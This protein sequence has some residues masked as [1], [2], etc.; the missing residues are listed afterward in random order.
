MS[1]LGDGVLKKS[2]MCSAVGLALLLGCTAPPVSPSATPTGGIGFDGS[3]NLQMASL[4]DDGTGRVAL[5]G[6]M[7]AYRSGVSSFTLSSPAGLTCTGQTDET[8][9]GQQTCSDGS[10]FTFT[11]PA[12][13]RG[14]LSG[15]YIVQAPGVR[16][17]VGWGRKANEAALVALLDQ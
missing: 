2:W 5:S 13:Q 8:W 17:A 7:K 3:V 10:T 1:K 16:I 12:D 4:Y 11:I 9:S 6:A 14:K 15:A